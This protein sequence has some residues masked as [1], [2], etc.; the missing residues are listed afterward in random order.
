MFGLLVIGQL[1]QVERDQL[2]AFERTDDDLLAL[3][4]VR[5]DRSDQVGKNRL[6][7]KAGHQYPGNEYLAG[8]QSVLTLG[9]AEIL[10]SHYYPTTGPSRPT[11]LACDHNLAR[12]WVVRPGAIVSANTRIHKPVTT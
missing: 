2:A 8:A 1:R 10:G 11:L 4:V 3:G 5:D 9:P 7:Q 12:D 6:Q